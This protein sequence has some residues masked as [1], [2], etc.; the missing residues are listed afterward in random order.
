[1]TRAE[2]KAN[3]SHIHMQDTALY[4]HVTII[5]GVHIISEKSMESPIHTRLLK[6]KSH[7]VIWS[8]EEEDDMGGH[9]HE[10]CTPSDCSPP[11]TL[12]LSSQTGS[13]QGEHTP[14]QPHTPSQFGCGIK[15]CEQAMTVHDDITYRPKAK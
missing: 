14:Q 4:W 8:S 9:T 3:T 11:T 2:C 13:R 6:R 1:M 12:G 10:A 7:K 5:L 15:Q